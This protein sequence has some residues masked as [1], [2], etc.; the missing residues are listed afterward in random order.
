[1]KKFELCF[2]H[3]ISFATIG[4]LYETLYYFFSKG[5]LVNSGTTLG[6]W[7]PIYGFGGLLIYLLSKK[8]KNNPLKMFIAS[9]I[10]SGIIEYSTSYYLE[11]VYHMRWW[12]YSKFAFNLNGRICLLGLITFSFLALFVMRFVLPI[13]E[14]IYNKMSE[15]FRTILICSLFVLFVID[16]TYSTFSPNTS[17]AKVVKESKTVQK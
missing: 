4:W 10:L 3:F 17:N 14:K 16:F 12:D 7:L 8:L 6:P 5:K 1:M 11:K 2:W 9:F 15:K 13:I